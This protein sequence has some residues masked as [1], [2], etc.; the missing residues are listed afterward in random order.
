MTSDLTAHGYRPALVAGRYRVT[1]VLATA[2]DGDVVTALDV[3]EDRTVVL[4]RVRRPSRAA[5]TRL[6]TVERILSGLRHPNVMD[7]LN[8]K[9]GKSDAWLVSER[10]PGRELLE[11]WSSLPL[12]QTAGFE[13]RWTHAAPII[14]CLLD[15]LAAM[16]RSQLAHLDV[17]PANVRV[18]M[19]GQ[20][21]LVDVGLGG[22]LGEAEPEE[23]DEAAL[24]G[25][26]G[27][28]AP[29][30]L[31]GLMVSQR[32]DQW[33]LGA[34][35]YLLMTG[36]RPLAGRSLDELR[37]SYERGR[38]QAPSEWRPDIP[39]DVERTMLRMMAWE[40][41][42]RFESIDA[43]REAFGHR[44][45]SAP[46][47]PHLPWSVEPPPTVGREPLAAFF[48]RRLNDLAKGRGGLVRIAAPRGAG[49]TRL[50]R[51]WLGQAEDHDGVDVFAA[52]CLPGWPRVALEGWFHA[53]GLDINL[54]PPKDIVET[55]LGQLTRPTVVLLDALEGLDA[56][57]WARVHRAAA[58]A[59]DEEAP[60]LLV[61]AGRQLPDLAPRVSPDA[62]RFFNV[63]LPRLN[64]RDVARLLRPSSADPEDLE[65]RDGAAESFC[66]EAHGLPG[67][68]LEV[69]LE[70]EA[71][72][73]L[74]REGQHWIVR[75]GEGIDEPVAP[76]RP[77]M[78]EQFLAW[79]I[80]LGGEV[81]VELLLSCLAMPRAA[82]VQGLRFAS[83]HGEVH[84]RD[85]GGRWYVQEVEG[86]VSTA[87][88]VYGK[89][90]THLRVARWLEA[91]GTAAG[92]TAE[93]VAINWHEGGDYTAAARSYQAASQ[94]EHVIGNTSDARRL[95]GIGRMLAARASGARK[96]K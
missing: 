79:I 78:H 53:E 15:G 51:D 20:A 50:L 72:G 55:W 69:F 8:L 3:K 5:T 44:L 84:F 58:A 37:H 86:A 83:E 1:D 23:V 94:A 68:L 52:S 65:I 17:K 89:H 73:R 38:V 80:E 2:D 14:K 77:N 21:R 81:E 31:D 90:E 63:E 76:A 57:T 46:G 93:R 36:R 66:D 56:V 67:R 88:T 7:V 62:P 70:D 48:R 43:A 49:K 10:V 33:S 26:F 59:S 40:P 82:V 16:H 13:E 87:V 54:P 74:V 19:L 11:W 6:R 64:P 32:A 61:L 45:T 29:E 25:W 9:E 41:E 28:L 12:L 24:D 75:V 39:E 96:K 30:L 27:Y 34:V 95:D 92:L 42:E 85:V 71:Q 47:Q 91:Q 35:I 22:G 4:K 18:D 60:L